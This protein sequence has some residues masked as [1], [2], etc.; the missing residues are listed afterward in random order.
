VDNS[1]TWSIDPTPI[2]DIHGVDSVAEPMIEFASGATRLSS[3]VVV[4]ADQYASRLGFF[5]SAGAPIRSIGRDGSGPG[6][7][8]DIRWIGT[9]G[10]DSLF[11]WDYTR[12][13]IMVFDTA[14]TF[15]RQYRPQ[16]SPHEFACSRHGAFG[17]LGLP[18]EFRPPSA[19]GTFLEAPVWIADDLGDSIHSLGV[20]RFGQYRPLGPLT[21]IAIGPDRFYVG[22][23]ESAWVNVFGTD[24]RELGVVPIGTG[25]RRA[26]VRNYERAIERMLA[27]APSRAVRDMQRPVLEALPMP[28]WI[29]PY[30]DLAVD[31]AGILWVV[32]SA[33][34]DGQTRLRAI[35]TD[36]TNVADVTLP[37]DVKVHEV[38][39]DYILG[40]AEDS[41]GSQH[42]LV[43]RLRRNHEQTGES[44]PRPDGRL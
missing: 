20:T 39:M 42:V 32:T 29:P 43:Y 31:P 11:V 19:D 8:S 5:D 15:G 13:M 9:C 26:T 18:I 3:G 41:L 17:V 10:V 16:G 6:E 14:G 34:G 23:A 12:R 24:G 1:A 2:T 22:T 7:F 27:V 36:R 25:R 4:V 38:G 40:V 30:V 21:R 35:G 44:D 33:P 37:G 28:E